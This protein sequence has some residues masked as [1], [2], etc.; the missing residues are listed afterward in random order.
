MDTAQHC[1]LKELNHI[2][3]HHLIDGGY[4]ARLKPKFQFKILSYLPDQPR[5]RE[6]A[7]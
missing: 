5:D 3:F 1:I 7:T 6:F 4:S 2:I